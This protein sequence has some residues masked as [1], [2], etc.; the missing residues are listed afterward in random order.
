MIQKLSRAKNA[1]VIALVV[2]ATLVAGAAADE[3]QPKSVAV[4]HPNLLLNKAEIEEI[5]LKV[6]EHAWAAQLLERVKKKAEEN[7]AVVEKALAY[8]LTGEVMYANDVRDRLLGETRD[9]MPHYEKL[10]V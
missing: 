6:R 3:N 2:L 8:V 10:D 5:K 4:R 9:Q 1:F 7:D